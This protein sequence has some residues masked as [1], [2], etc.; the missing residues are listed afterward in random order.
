MGKSYPL[1]IAV[2]LTLLPNF[3]LPSTR[4][5]RG[6]CGRACQVAAD[7]LVNLS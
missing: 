6:A 3:Q 7:R 4:G 1:G 5:S 2:N